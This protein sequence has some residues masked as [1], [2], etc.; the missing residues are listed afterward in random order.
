MS[1]PWR[2]PVRLGLWRRMTITYFDDDLLGDDDGDSEVLFEED[3]TGEDTEIGV[4]R[5]TDR[6]L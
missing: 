4:Q 2:Q 1:L 5:K 6:E 3:V